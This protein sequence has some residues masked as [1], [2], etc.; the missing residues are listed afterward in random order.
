MAKTPYGKLGSEE[1]LSAHLNG[2]Q[3]SIN[4]VEEIL[5][6]KTATKTGVALTPYADMADKAARYR[7]YE[8]PDSNWLYTPAPVI[9]RNK[10]VVDASEYDLKAEY[11]AI[12]FHV[13]Q[14]ETDVIT[15]DY[16]HIINQSTKMESME[17]RITALEQNGGSGG[18]LHY[19]V[20]H[21][22][23]TYRSHGISP[24]NTAT[25]VAVL[26]NSI[27]IF[28]FKVYE[29][30]ICDMMGAQ[31]STAGTD[32]LTTFAVYT[33]NNG[34][35]ETL[36]A[37]T[38]TVDCSTTGWKEAVFTTGD[39]TLN[40]G[41]YWIGRFTNNGISF[42]GLSPAGINPV[43]SAPP[44]GSTTI[45]NSN[46]LGAGVGGIRY[47]TTFGTGTFPATFPAIGSGPQYLER[48][49]YASPWIRR[50]PQ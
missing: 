30:I 3:R 5:D 8:G 47:T 18:L 25:G 10:V 49:A 7:I 11:G 22:P 50:K 35:P 16:T 23:G 24:Q 20:K 19:L 28:P 41:D 48:N 42:H 37:Q 33:D 2:I 9:K 31:V 1:I 32:A 27:D 15:A 21:Y 43:P 6:M 44:L 13:Q 34:Y 12:V 36:I 29:T 17:S 40:A 46:G 45:N 38:D 39:V 4:N 14:N 26:S